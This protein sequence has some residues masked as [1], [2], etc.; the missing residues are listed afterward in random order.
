LLVL[1][2]VFSSLA[3]VA[4]AE[5]GGVSVA[6]GAASAL[7]GVSTTAFALSAA[8]ATAVAVKPHPSKTAPTNSA[9]DSVP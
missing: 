9:R 8:A 5:V 2:S 1:E 6:A 7:D 4:A 3:S